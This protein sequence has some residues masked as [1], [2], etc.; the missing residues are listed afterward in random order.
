[1][2]LRREVD[3]LLDELIAKQKDSNKEQ[4]EEYSINNR[5][6]I[7]DLKEEI[8]KLTN[9]GERANGL[10]TDSPEFY[11]KDIYRDN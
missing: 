6:A 11:C 3:D 4:G 10:W 7:E 1:M 9:S 8:I 2:H 5:L